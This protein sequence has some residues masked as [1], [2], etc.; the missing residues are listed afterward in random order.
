ME[1][2]RLQEIGVRMSNSESEVNSETEQLGNQSLEEEQEEN[3][4]A[5]AD[6]QMEQFRQNELNMEQMRS[7]Q[8]EIMLADRQIQ[9]EKRINELGM[10][11]YITR[12]V[13]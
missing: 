7:S 6:Q 11:T 4:R 12:H 13:F 8:F 5:E 2:K 1:N 3:D 9:E 10:Y